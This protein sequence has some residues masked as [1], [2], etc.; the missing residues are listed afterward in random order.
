MKIGINLIQYTDVQGIEVY[1]YN[2]LSS[3]FS[4]DKNNEYILFVNKK[5]SQIFDFHGSNIRKIEVDIGKLSKLHLM[6]FQQLNFLFLLWREQIDL[7][8]CPSIA[9]PLFYGKKM[10]TILDCAGLRFIEE[11][12]FLSL[13]YI[14]LA[15]FSAKYF[16]KGIITISNFSKNEIRKFIKLGSD[17]VNVAYCGV[18]KMP[19]VS[20]SELQIVLAKFG[21][22]NNDGLPKKYFF[23]I[24]NFRP[25][26]NL[27]RLLQAFSQLVKENNDSY[28]V[29][30]GKVEKRFFDIDL[31]L[32][33]KEFSGRLIYAGVIDDREKVILYKNSL[34]LCFVSLYEGFG[35]PLLE[36][37]SLDVPVL[38]SMTSSLPEVAGDGALF[39]DP[40]SVSDIYAGMKKMIS[41][42]SLRAKLITAGHNN[43]DNF[44][45]DKSAKELISLFEIKK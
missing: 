22:L 14:R 40:Y 33:K 31:E 15:F 25:R 18:P 11:A 37:Q 4:Q 36:A 13:I 38:T 24:G 3:V 42:P 23:Y 2:V 28:L 41:D 6:L 30:A 10:V 16:S 7:L 26:K 43:C 5:S 8:Y 1:A 45:W 17:F 39:V 29:L 20:E 27:P 34:A 9:M 35:L 19:S 12:S 44:S 21:L 32:S